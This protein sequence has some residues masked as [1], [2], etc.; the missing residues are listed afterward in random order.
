M[1]V[2]VETSEGV[3]ALASPD[4]L[5]QFEGRGWAAVGGCTDRYREP[6]LT[7]SEHTAAV[8]VEAERIAAL[9]KSDV[10][11]ASSRPSK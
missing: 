1:W 11:P 9:L 7:D 5:S 6:I 10:A 4:A 2:V 8:A 3:R